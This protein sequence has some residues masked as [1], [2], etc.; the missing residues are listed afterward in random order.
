ME[1]QLTSKQFM[2]DLITNAHQVQARITKLKAR[3]RR[4]PLWKRIVFYKRFAKIRNK[5]KELEGI[6]LGLVAMS[7]SI[8]RSLR[9]RR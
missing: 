3:L 2:T 1:R 5:I 7:M 8:A 4:F 9:K 6:R